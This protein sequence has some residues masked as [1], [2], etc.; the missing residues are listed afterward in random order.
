MCDSTTY[1][2][3]MATNT[4]TTTETTYNP[5]T[6]TYKSE[7][8]A[9]VEARTLRAARS[10]LA[11]GFHHVEVEFDGREVTDGVFFYSGKVTCRNRE[12][13]MALLVDKLTVCFHAGNLGKGTRFGGA[14][15]LGV[16]TTHEAATISDAEGLFRCA[17]EDYD[18]A[19]EAIDFR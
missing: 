4:N 19:W 9:A 15:K 16:T 1:I 14:Y 11:A 10:I 2:V 7:V 17:A 8:S 13:K 12:D 6:V 18:T 3:C 5:M